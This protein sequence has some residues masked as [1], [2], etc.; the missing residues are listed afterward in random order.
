MCLTFP[1]RGSL[2][3]QAKS[4]SL[5]T[6]ERAIRFCR[7]RGTGDES[8]HK[9]HRVN[10]RTTTHK[11]FSIIH[12]QSIQC[13]LQSAFPCKLHQIPQT[14]WNRPAKRF[15]ATIR[16]GGPLTTSAIFR[17]REIDSFDQ[18]RDRD[19]ERQKTSWCG[20][21]LIPIENAYNNGHLPKS[22]KLR[23]FNK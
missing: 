2:L 9:N 15:E 8:S 4:C 5:R 16:T 6:Q 13:Q 3:S 17:C 18:N 22:K 21:F 1:S 23:A 12:T 11:R 14:G 19:R 20:N 7:S 10:T